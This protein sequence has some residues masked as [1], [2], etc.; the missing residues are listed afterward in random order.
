MPPTNPAAI[1]EA[2]ERI[3][4][5]KYQDDFEA[6]FKRQFAAIDTDTEA[7]FVALTPEDALQQARAANP[8]GVFHLVRIGSEGVFRTA[9]ASTPQ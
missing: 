5:E 9:V 6:K 1:A 7:A 4:R 3:Y 8:R 2:G